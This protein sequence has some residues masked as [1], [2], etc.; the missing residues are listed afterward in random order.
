[1]VKERKDYSSTTYLLLAEKLSP[2]ELT[3]I[4]HCAV[5]SDCGIDG[6]C[7]IQDKANKIVKG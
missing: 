3:C 1:M 7:K 5:F 6:N 4:S 2:E